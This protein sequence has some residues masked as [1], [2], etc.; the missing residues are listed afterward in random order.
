VKEL[1]RHREIRLYIAGQSL[2]GLGDA[3]LWLAAAIWIK[4]LTGSAGAAG[5]VMFFF[6]LSSL[7]GPVI[8]MVADRMRRLP[9]IIG[10]NAAGMAV[11][12][13]MLFV[14]GSD[15]VWVVYAVM[16]CYGV[17]NH[18]IMTAQSALLATVV[19]DRLLVNAN[20]VIRSIQESMRIGV[21][22]LGAGLFAWQG[23]R[24]VVLLD[25]VTFAG[26]IAIFAMM[27]PNESKPERASGEGRWGSEILAGA[28]YVYG[29]PVL[30]SVISGWTIA[31]LVFGFTESGLFAV[32]TDGLHRTAPFVGVLGMVQGVGA[33]VSGLLV[34]RIAKRVGEV[35]LIAL[36]L[37]GLA[38]A[39]LLLVIPS[40]PW[41]LGAMFL[42]GLALP[43]ALVGA[44]SVLQR[45]TPNNLQG[46]VYSCADFFWSGASIASIAIG[47]GLLTLIN[48]QTLFLVAT[49]FLV[50]GSAVVLTGRRGGPPPTPDDSTVDSDEVEDALT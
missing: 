26:A 49:A 8:G 18:I 30:R 14:T 3:S 50:I 41:V 33:I 6:G 5:M 24:A 42:A 37:V 47:A 28:R 39:L 1:L 23:I 44:I 2:S 9:L 29:H 17:V 43:L 27:R 10:A 12:L 40:L 13:P 19:P 46:R 21:P 7:F 32:V 25:L 16:L 20:G 4:A 48:Y 36:G 11:V 45:S 38:G 35:Q 34:G 31:A 15:A 22:L